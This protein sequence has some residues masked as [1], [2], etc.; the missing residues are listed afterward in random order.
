MYRSYPVSAVWEP[1]LSENHFGG[2]NKLG[3][4]CIGGSG[5]GRGWVLVIRNNKYRSDFAASLSLQ[6]VVMIMV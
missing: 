1:H 3:L 6:R 4:G 2:V 5:F